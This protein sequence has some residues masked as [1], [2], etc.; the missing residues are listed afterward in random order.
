MGQY[1]HNFYRTSYDHYWLQVPY[2]KSNYRKKF[3]RSLVNTDLGPD[4][5]KLFLGFNFKQY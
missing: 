4:F 1:L 5:I 3:V 2:Y